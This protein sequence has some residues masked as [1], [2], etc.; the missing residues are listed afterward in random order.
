MTAVMMLTQLHTLQ[1]LLWF[2]PHSLLTQLHT[3]QDLLWFPPHSLLTQLH[4]LQDLLW[5]PPHSLFSPASVASGGLLQNN[6]P[7][8]SLALAV[9]LFPGPVL[10]GTG[11][12][13]TPMTTL[14]GAWRHRVSALTGWPCVSILWLGEIESWICNFCLSLAAFTNVQADLS[15]R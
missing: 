14:P 9:D 2:P 6:R 7:E 12:S 1:D 10:P 15:L 13:G 5:F 11:D 4:T 3:L 8:S